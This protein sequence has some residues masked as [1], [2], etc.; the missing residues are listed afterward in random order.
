MNN[1]EKIDII[2]FVSMLGFAIGLL[3]N[4]L[5]GNSLLYYPS[6]YHFPDYIVTI[7]VLDNVYSDISIGR[8]YFPF[9]YIILNI[10]K[11]IFDLNIFGYFVTF[12]IT[13]FLLFYFYLIFIKNV[14]YKVLITFCLLIFSYPILFEFDRA[15]VEYLVLAFLLMFFMAY[16]KGNYR[17]ASILLSF[18]ICMKLYPALFIILFLKEKKYKEFITSTVVSVLLMIIGFIMIGGNSSNIS[19]A[20]ENFS[21]FTT[22]FAKNG[23]GIPYNHTIW[24][25]LSVLNLKYGTLSINSFG[26]QFIQIYTLIIVIIAILLVLYILFIEK[27]EW[28]I[29]AILTIMMITFPHVSFDYTLIHMYI[30]ILFFITC[31]DTKKWENI[32][33]SILLGISIIPMNWFQASISP[34]ITLNL[35]LLIRPLVLISI[36]AIIVVTTIYKRKENYIEA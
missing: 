15:N 26:E 27:S 8:G 17:L 12:A 3:F 20:L 7:N 35:G 34:A 9:T 14:K 10:I 25:L 22:A 2:F 31:K 11:A 5:G 36:I 28:K 1:T 30:P 18:P 33:F 4:V 13:I 21:F 6:A 23:A 32:V 16:K 24:T 19:I 29:V